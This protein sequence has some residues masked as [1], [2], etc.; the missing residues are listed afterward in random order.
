MMMTMTDTAK[1]VWN[2]L[3]KKGLTPA[4]A[5][6][7]MGNLQAESGINPV[8]LENLCIKRY[9]ERRG[10]TYTSESYMKQ[11]NDGTIS[12]D[13]F[14]RPMGLQYAWGLAQWTS[15]N[16]KAGLY[17]L[18]K[19]VGVSIGDLETQ[20]DY[21]MGELS[22][23]YSSVYKTLTTTKDILTASN[24][25]LTKFE[26]PADT[27]TSVRQVRYNYSK[28]IYDEMTASATKAS[29]AVNKDKCISALITVAKAEVGYLEKAS[30]SQ[31]DSKTA[32][33]GSGNY[34]KYWRDVYPIYQGQAW[35]AC[36]V[37]WCFMQVFGK[38]VAEKLLKHWPF[39]YCPTLANLTSNKTPKKGSIVLFYRNGTYAHT[40]LVINVSG[41]TITTIEGNTSGASGIIPNGGGVC[42]KSYNT[43]NLSGMTKYFMPDY[44]I[45]TKLYAGAT[46]DAS[47]STSG[48]SGS[49]STSQ[50]TSSTPIT[51]KRATQPATKY[52]RSLAGTYTVTASALNIRDGAGTGNAVL[53]AIPKGTTVQNYGYYSTVGSVKWLYIQVT[54]GGVKYTGFCSK[55]YLQK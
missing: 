31:F 14:L 23:S 27:G 2:Y 51:E 53:G 29:T 10:I 34:T 43:T 33:A 55:K 3:I 35:C 18:C 6:G 16:R 28:A 45:V 22:T 39:V 26:M 17:D 49:V 36:F 1:K 32:N 37:S 44:D 5:A 8:C 15:P 9:K 38:A 4:G 47:T 11:V 54:Y 52:S 48:A 25:V 40:G 41:T 21:L 13:E 12:R 30:N 7:M 24:A 42:Q 19:Q 20:L 46:A 50:P